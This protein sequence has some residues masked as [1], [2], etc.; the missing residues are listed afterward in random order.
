MRKRT[1]LTT[2][3]VEDHFAEL[4]GLPDVENPFAATER[5]I[6]TFAVN[7]QGNPGACLSHLYQMRRDMG[8]PTDA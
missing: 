6:R 3:D 8:G 1:W 5:F 4:C 7:E 2:D